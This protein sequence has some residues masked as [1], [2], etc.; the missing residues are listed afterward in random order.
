[1]KF[2][3]SQCLGIIA[4]LLVSL[5]LTAQDTP[6][7][8]IDDKQV[9]PGQVIG[10]DVLVSNYNDIVSSAFIV[11]WDSMMLRY[12]GIDNIAFGLSE[13]DNFNAMEATGGNLTYLY[14]DNSLS[15]NTLNDGGALFTLQL[16]VIGAEGEQTLVDFGGLMEVVDTSVVDLNADFSGG[17]ITIGEVNSTSIATALPLRAEV[18]PNPFSKTANVIIEL[19]EGGEIFW[20]LS[21]ISGQR[22]MDGKTTYGPGSHVLELKN[23]LFKHTG[24]Y[25]LQLQMGDVFITRRLLYVAP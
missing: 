19:N 2:Q 12:V 16:E 22:I 24:A 25:I 17:L 15:G 5:S 13:D 21:E 8:Y 7:I 11:T 3:P 4:L 18:S 10:L 20:T 9:E 6:S 1:M 14:F 23:T